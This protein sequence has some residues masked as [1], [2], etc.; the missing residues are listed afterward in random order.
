M[1]ALR[2][3]L[4]I[5]IVAA[6]PLSAQDD[7][8]FAADAFL[9]ESPTTSDPVL[10]SLLLDHT[11]IKPGSTFT[12]LIKLE[13]AP[14]WGTYYKNPGSSGLPT[15]VTWTLP[16]GVTAGAL[17]F[18]APKIK[19]FSGDPVY[20]FKETAWFRTRISVS[21]DVPAALTTI[22]LSAQVEWLV[23]EKVQ[24]VPGSA[25]LTATVALGEED[26]ANPEALAPLEEAA[27]KIPAPLPESWKLT[28]EENILHIEAPGATPLAE[29]ETLFFFPSAAAWLTPTFK[30]ENDGW[31]IRLPEIT[32]EVPTPLAGILVRSKE[33]WS[34]E[35]SRHA[36]LIGGSG[37]SGGASTAGGPI[38]LGG[39]QEVR[40][41]FWSVLPFAFLGGLILNLMPCVFPILGIKIMGFV[42][43]AGED[44]SK[45]KLHG[46]VF[47]AGVVVSM[48]VLAGV[49]I[50]LNA[51]GEQ[52]G[53]GFQLQSPGFLAGI[54]ILFFVFA[55]NLTGLF[56][57]GTSLTGV[58]G[59]LQ[60]KKGYS[61]SFFSGLL[62]TLIATPCSGPF[63]G[64]VMGFT[65][66]QP[67]LNA[68]T[69]FL[70]FALGIA[71]P[72]LILSF[73][74][75]LIQKLPRPGAW[76]VTFKK[77]M[78]FPMFAT[79]VF[80]MNAYFGMTGKQGAILI[81]G[82]FVSYAF[83]LWIYGH[84]CT[85]VK[86][87]PTRLIGG[88]FALLFIALGIWMTSH[89]IKARPPETSGN[90]VKVTHG[91][92]WQR[93]SPGRVNELRK[94]GMLVYVDFTAD[95]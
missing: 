20:G 94:Q 24:C 28:L 62:T 1:N 2:F 58:G 18:P 10:A 64:P 56:E 3:F 44:K 7:D 95:W 52:Y 67:A 91:M 38:T 31:D 36:L 92:E 65:L 37:D 26:L 15:T 49:L 73:F 41:T 45:V 61:G 89:S 5:V 57:L 71:S 27:G 47:T 23:C 40:Y 87:R 35:I 63:L 86:P 51:A 84:W 50:G 70:V 93:W 72:Y 79:V 42:Q 69:I 53:W 90:I 55:L 78:A 48:L 82:A 11:V 22:T 9:D 25:G 80:F 29:G 85:I 83:G 32:G 59:N 13:H 14:G 46:M 17:E 68:L 81:L 74:P 60:R 39:E 21:P 6:L 33:N 43:Q 30:Q 16:E 8:P 77:F 88:T 66:N 75:D 76:M 12:A 54:L 4:S 19:N 34:A